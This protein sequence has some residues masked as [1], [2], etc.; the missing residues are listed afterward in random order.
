M[1]C[2]EIRIQGII[3]SLG[4]FLAV[5]IILIPTIMSGDWLKSIF[6]VSLFINT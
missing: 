5:F 1:S 2:R 4:S 3:S 6:L